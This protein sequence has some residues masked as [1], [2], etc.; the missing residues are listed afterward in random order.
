M[1]LGFPAVRTF[2]MVKLNFLILSQLYSAGTFH[3]RLRLYIEN[4]LWLSISSEAAADEL[5]TLRENFQYRV[6]NGS[7]INFF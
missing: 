2:A 1:D 4:L 5:Q 3:Q 7:K 6:N